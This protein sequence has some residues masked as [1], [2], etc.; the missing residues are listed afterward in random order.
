MPTT[1]SRSASRGLTVDA[2]RAVGP[3]ARRRVPGSSALLVEPVVA[4]RWAEISVGGRGETMYSMPEVTSF[5]TTVAGSEPA[6]SHLTGQPGVPS[7][8]EDL[9]LTD[10]GAVVAADP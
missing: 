7:A 6:A 2:G 5:S 8:E 10:G 3:H 1:R 4:S 9:V